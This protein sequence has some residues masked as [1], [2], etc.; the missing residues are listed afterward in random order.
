MKIHLDILIQM[1]K[2]K[3]KVKGKMKIQKILIL[4]I[5]FYILVEKIFVLK[6][7]LKA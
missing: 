3:A 5:I 1:I 6:K 4:M 2:V 7:K